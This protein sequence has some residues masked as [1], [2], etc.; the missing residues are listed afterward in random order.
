[1]ILCDLAVC[2]MND[3]QFSETIL[4][5]EEALNLEP[6]NDKAKDC[7]ETAKFFQNEFDKLNKS[8]K[9]T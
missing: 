1:L 4:I 2:Y 6:N 8:K 3:R 5:L 9:K 7:L